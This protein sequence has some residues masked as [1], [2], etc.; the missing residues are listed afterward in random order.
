MNSHTKTLNKLLIGGLLISMVMG[1]SIYFIE[2]HK[3]DDYVERL[4]YEESIKYS[5]FYNDYYRSPA[6]K[7]YSI[8]STII[9]NTLK[10]D[11]FITIEIY[12]QNLKKIIGR[13]ALNE[14]GLEEKLHDAFPKFIMSGKTELVKKTVEGQKLI[15]VMSPIRSQKNNEV[16][17][18]FEGVFHINGNALSEIENKILLSVLQSVIVIIT[19]TLLLYPIILHLNKRL[20][21]LSIDLLTS[22]INT[23]KSLGSAIAKRDSDTNAHNYRVTI[24]SVRIAEALSLP[25]QQ[26]QSLIKGAFLHDIGKI[27]ISDTILL[28]P[29]KL[30]SE[31]FRV[32]KQHVLL[33]VDI[34]ENNDWLKDAYDVIYYHHEKYDGSGYSQGLMGESIPKNARIFSIADVFDALTS[35]RPYKEA[36]SFEKAMKILNEGADS[37]FDPQILAA[38]EIIANKLYLEISHLANDDVLSSYLDEITSQYFKILQ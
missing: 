23:I 30:T 28:K 31:E 9:E 24:Y 17:A 32:M 13:S 19:T 33:G 7:S 27:G 15:K 29:G 35:K 20:K 5:E 4:S 3:I 16:I 14:Q 36:F 37:H 1:T 34:I 21:K 6:E 8:L 2:Y 22:N 25:T 12:D 10:H 18:H 26:I 38:F 11:L